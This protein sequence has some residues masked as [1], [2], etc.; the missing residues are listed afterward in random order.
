MVK[1]WKEVIFQIS[2]MKRNGAKGLLLFTRMRV[3]TKRGSLR[4]GGVSFALRDLSCA[5]RR[6]DVAL[7]LKTRRLS[8]AISSSAHGISSARGQRQ[9][10]RW[11]RRWRRVNRAFRSFLRA[12]PCTFTHV[13]PSGS[14]KLTR[15]TFFYVFHVAFHN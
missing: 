15:V 3:P 5:K 9:R 11:W 10:R 6:S 8:S 2:H 12:C 7:I 4:P 1:K 14:C 13:L